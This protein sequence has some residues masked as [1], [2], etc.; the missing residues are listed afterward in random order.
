[1]KRVP[2]LDGVRGL[3]ILLVLLL[4]TWGI[5][6]GMFGV[7]LFFVLSGFL[8]TGI[9]L[10]EQERTG[11]FDLRRFYARRAVRLVPPLILMLIVVVP[12]ASAWS[13]QPRHELGSALIG[14]GYITN[15]ALVVHP[16]S[17][18][19]N[20]IHLWS[21]AAEEQFYLVWPPLLVLLW[22]RKWL[23]IALVAAAGLSVADYFWIAS[24][25]PSYWQDAG[26]DAHAAP[27]ILGCAA[28]LIHRRGVRFPLWAGCFGLI[29]AGALVVL[30][31]IRPGAG[32]FAAF[33]AAAVPPILH[34]ADGDSILARVFSL[35][36]L[37]YVGRI[38]YSLYLWNSPVVILVAGPW[39]VPAGMSFLLAAGCWR[40]LE[41]PLLRWHA[42]RTRIPRP[43][44]AAA[45]AS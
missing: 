24:A 16:A 37:R 31:S 14:L 19:S 43:L 23:P 12:L 17:V 33:A 25:P 6:G 10:D 21:L 11:R 39:F 8:I 2:A 18:G 13:H 45:S 30:H 3:A 36:P 28:A 15:I 34:L 7:D 38:S 9:L 35:R 22:K 40:Y 20:F 4:H 41:N 26:P 42:T 5:D 44:P 1:V 27:I 32:Y 29:A